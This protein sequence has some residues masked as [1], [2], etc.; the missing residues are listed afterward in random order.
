MKAINKV[1]PDKVNTPNLEHK[2][3]AQGVFYT[4]NQ[5][6]DIFKVQNNL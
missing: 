3:L 4:L 5:A 2:M 6:W 1:H